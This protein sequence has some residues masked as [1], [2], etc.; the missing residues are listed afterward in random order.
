[1]NLTRNP[2]EL[3]RGASRTR[4]TTVFGS[5]W[6]RAS[7]TGEPLASCGTCSRPTPIS[8]GWR[9]RTTLKHDRPQQTR[10]G[11]LGHR[12]GGRGAGGVFGKLF[13]SP[14]PEGLLAGRRRANYEAK[15]IQNPSELSNRWRVGRAHARSSAPPRSYSSKGILGDDRKDEWRKMEKPAR[16]AASP[17]TYAAISDV[18]P[19]LAM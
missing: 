10:R 12:G 1:M 17:L 3:G 11:V 18:P 19:S 5:S 8:L 15:H 14:R 6:R 16:I 2:T 4:P 9:G 13:R 7:P